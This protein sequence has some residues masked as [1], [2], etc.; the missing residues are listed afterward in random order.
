MERAVVIALLVAIALVIG[1]VVVMRVFYRDS[2]ALDK[3]ID[4]GKMREWKDDD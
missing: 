1:Y 4:L 3:K 2:D